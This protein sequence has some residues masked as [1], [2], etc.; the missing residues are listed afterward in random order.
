MYYIDGRFTKVLFDEFEKFMILKNINDDIFSPFDIDVVWKA[1]ILDTKFYYNY[2]NEKFGKIIH[3]YP[4]KSDTDF[5]RIVRHKMRLYKSIKLYKETFN[6]QPPLDVWGEFDYHDYMSVDIWEEY[7]T[8][9]PLSGIMIQLIIE[10]V[11]DGISCWWCSNKK[12]IINKYSIIVDKCSTIGTIKKLINEKHG[13]PIINKELTCNGVSLSR[14][15]FT[16]KHYNIQNN[17][18]LTYK[19]ELESS[20]PR[21]C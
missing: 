14:D 9:I 1:C 15:Y 12:P 13:K 20:N 19:V 16:L 3:H 18:T 5:E 17:S 11:G 2:C 21:T 4:D 7:N 6:E 10:D 8:S